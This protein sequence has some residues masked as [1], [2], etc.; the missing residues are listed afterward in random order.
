MIKG[1]KIFYGLTI[2]F[3]IAI[4]LL[5]FIVSGCG[6]GTDV[7]VKAGKWTVSPG[8]SI[9][10]TADT[11][12][13]YD[14]YSIRYYWT[15]VAENCGRLSS[16][17]GKS[18]SWTAPPPIEV[19][20]PRVCTIEVEVITSNNRINDPVNDQEFITVTFQIKVN[21]AP[22]TNK[23]PEITQFNVPLQFVYRGETVS[24]SVVASDPEGGTLKYYWKTT[25]GTIVGSGS[26]ISWTAPAIIPLSGRCTVSVS[27]EDQLRAASGISADFTI[28]D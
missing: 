28:I 5:V 18:V 11:R 17:T 8:E 9:R 20:A 23:P 12:N 19:P 16:T 15:I 25:C 10:L 21:P 14:G 3:C 7:V 27:V 2:L 13:T 24:L 6:E 26:G 1:E 4:V 22:V